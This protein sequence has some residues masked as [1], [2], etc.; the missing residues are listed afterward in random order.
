[1]KLTRRDLFRTA[2]AAG[3]ASAVGGTAAVGTGLAA[4][5]V[6]GASSRYTTLNR[7]L[8]ISKPDRRGWS[9]ILRR[10]GEPHVVRTAL[11]QKAKAGRAR[12]RTPILSFA[13]MSDVHVVDAQ[14]PA[15]L[16]SGET[17]STSPTDPRR[18]SPPTSR[19]RWSAG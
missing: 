15:R 2:G 16:E 10:P 7:T 9:R 18:C 13:Q 11:C 4:K 17:I 8:V 6:A 19:N 14:S 1:M 3:A 5:A 12:R